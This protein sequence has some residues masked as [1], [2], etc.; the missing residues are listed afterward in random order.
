MEWLV[1]DV[2]A[3]GGDARR[4]ELIRIRQIYIPELV[5][6]THNLLLTSRQHVSG[7]LQRA[8]GLAKI[9]ADSRYKVFEDFVNEGGRGLEGRGLGAGANKS[10]LSHLSTN[11][12]NHR[13]ADYLMMVRDAAVAGLENGGSD[14]FRVVM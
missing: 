4:R 12:S 11:D 5:M 9:V 2:E 1:A 13:L 8:L 10:D 6:R 7:N 3:A 14:P